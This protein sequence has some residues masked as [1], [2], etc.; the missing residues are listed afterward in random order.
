MKH[1]DRLITYNVETTS[2]TT[3]EVFTFNGGT[4]VQS[5]DSLSVYAIYRG[6]HR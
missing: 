1:I 4:Q 6:F 2:E 5:Y 3:A